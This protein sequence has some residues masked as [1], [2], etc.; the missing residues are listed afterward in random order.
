MSKVTIYL[1]IEDENGKIQ[2]NSGRM[3]S[4]A[5][6]P[7]KVS[8]DPV[9]EAA[10]GDPNVA[11]CKACLAAYLK[12][13][14]TVTDEDEALENGDVNAGESSGDTVTD[15][16]TPDAESDQVDEEDADE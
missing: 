7:D 10:T 2:G 15:G 1:L 3:F 16:V 14:D 9:T 12:L 13:S 6:D 4:V 5:S 8:F 11:N